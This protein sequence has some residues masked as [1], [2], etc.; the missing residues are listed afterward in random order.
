MKLNVLEDGEV[1][2]VE[3]TFNEKDQ[4]YTY[5]V[6]KGWLVSFSPNLHFIRECLDVDFKR[7][8]KY[9][10]ETGIWYDGDWSFIR[11]AED[12]QKTQLVNLL[13]NDSVIMSKLKQLK[14]S[15]YGMGLALKNVV[16]I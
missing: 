2:S 13:A 3:A 1:L 15:S 8:V 4:S 11:D 5:R 6:P 14:L 12:E 16:S 7:T 9:V 10:K